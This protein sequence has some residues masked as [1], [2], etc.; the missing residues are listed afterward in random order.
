MKTRWGTCNPEAKRI[1]INLEL[2]KK[3]IECLE[4]IIV[5][6]MIHF[7]EKNIIKNSKLIWISFCLNGKPIKDS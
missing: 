6:E 7:F 4:Y 2:I 1:W 5:H 3:P